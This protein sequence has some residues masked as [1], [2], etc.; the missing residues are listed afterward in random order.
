MK[1]LKKLFSVQTSNGIL[2]F[3]AHENPASTTFECEIMRE[4][5]SSTM[6]EMIKYE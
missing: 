2:I 5:G 6:I 4:S 1:N 3:I